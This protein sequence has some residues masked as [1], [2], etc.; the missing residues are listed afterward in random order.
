MNP[1]SLI[2]SVYVVQLPSV[3]RVVLQRVGGHTDND[4]GGGG[5]GGG[6]IRASRL[7]LTH[8]MV[9][10]LIMKLIG[11][12]IA[13]VELKGTHPVIGE[14]ITSAV[15]KISLWKYI[16]RFLSKRFFVFRFMSC[17]RY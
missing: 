1:W 2:T 12:E 9:L 11:R 3:E 15:L 4:N 17:L 13:A 10:S 16:C 6:R 7:H 8:V 14:T 5:G